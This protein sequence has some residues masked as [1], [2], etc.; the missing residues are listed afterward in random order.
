MKV[1]GKR[2]AAHTTSTNKATAMSPCPTTLIPAA[3]P[4]FSIQTTTLVS[5][6]ESFVDHRKRS[7]SW[8]K[9]LGCVATMDFLRRKLEHVS[10]DK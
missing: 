9:F 5:D 3:F 1:T 6:V 8:E 10:V 4:H 7:W 2:K